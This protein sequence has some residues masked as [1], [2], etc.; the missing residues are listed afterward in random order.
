MAVFQS[1]TKK[2]CSEFPQP[3]EDVQKAVEGMI[4]PADRAVVGTED[5]VGHLAV[6]ACGG[7]GNDLCEFVSRRS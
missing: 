2:L 1:P 3:V 7:L 4:E 6:E 5:L